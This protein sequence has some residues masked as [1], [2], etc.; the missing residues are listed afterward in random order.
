[1]GSEGPPG[2]GPGP[3]GD[4]QLRPGPAAGGTTAGDLRR[5]GG[6]REKEGRR[7]GSGE[8]GPR[9]LPT[10]ASPNG[11][12]ARVFRAGRG[13]GPE[14]RVP[15]FQGGGTAPERSKGPRVAAR[16]SCRRAVCVWGGSSAFLR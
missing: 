12:A 14:G 16:G 6:K 3:A 1:M 2:L 10:G 5:G 13:A 11:A 7:E 8:A 4:A 9:R 15:P